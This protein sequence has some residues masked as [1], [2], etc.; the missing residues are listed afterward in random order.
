MQC[1]LFFLCLVILWNLIL[2]IV[3][4][5][6]SKAYLMLMIWSIF[7]SSSLRHLVPWV[8]ALDVG[9]WD[10]YIW[11]LF[12][13]LFLTSFSDVSNCIYVLATVICYVVLYPINREFFCHPG[14]A[15][16]GVQPEANYN[17]P[18]CCLQSQLC[19]WWNCNF[20]DPIA[21]YL[22]LIMQKSISLFNLKPLFAW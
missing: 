19:E 8:L 14:K 1:F 22:Y 17:C 12:R 2:W 15:W 4:I 20:L 13:F 6:F 11:R 3:T 7:C 18:Q 10:F 16:E 21:I 9:F 5:K